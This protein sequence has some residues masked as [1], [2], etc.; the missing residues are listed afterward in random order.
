MKAPTAGMPD[1]A[2]INGLD[3]L[4]AL[5]VIAVMLSHLPPV[6]GG[7]SQLATLL[8]TP[9]LGVGVDLFFVISGF[10]IFR[11]LLAI[12]RRRPLRAIAGFWIRRV[13]PAAL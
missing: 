11:Q 8:W 5:A 10:V 2:R 4:R 7:S 9:A 6:L 13:A 1:T 3:E 12:E